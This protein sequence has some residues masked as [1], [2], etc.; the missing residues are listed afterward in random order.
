[1]NAKQRERDFNPWVELP[2]LSL[3]R[4]AWTHD[5]SVK[6]ECKMFPASSAPVP[7]D[8]ATQRFRDAIT[9]VCSQ[10]VA[11]VEFFGALTTVSGPSWHPHLVTEAESLRFRTLVYC[12][13][14]DACPALQDAL[15]SLLGKAQVVPYRRLF[16][17][18]WSVT[19]LLYE[20]D[21]FIVA[22]DGWECVPFEPSYVL[23]QL[24]LSQSIRGMNLIG[25]WF[26]AA[27]NPGPT[28]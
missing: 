23:H 10:L 2:A 26:E 25:D 16:R 18:A 20:S 1:M 5:T 9:S 28:F 15:S 17:P 4:R 19:K 12:P 22:S 6:F 3:A 13:H 27:K 14:H 8:F 21:G 7:K 24:E 11:T